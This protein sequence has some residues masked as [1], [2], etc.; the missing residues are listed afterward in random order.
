MNS[1]PEDGSRSSITR[2]ELSDPSGI[3][4][5]KGSTEKLDWLCWQLAF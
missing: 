2:A 5:W 1:E 3:D 4:F